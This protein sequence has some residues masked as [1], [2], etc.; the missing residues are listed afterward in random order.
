MF[1]VA[2]LITSM[3][4]ISNTIRITIFSRRREIEIMK[5]VGATNWFIRWPFIVEGML[6]GLIGAVVP[7]LVL[8]YG[9]RSLYIRAK[10]VFSGLSFPLVQAGDLGVKLAVILL[11]IGLFI[12]LW[13]ASCLFAASSVFKGANEFAHQSRRDTSTCI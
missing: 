7:V 5:L 8:V 12:G 2:L 4:L 10:G 11:A 6:I 13:G 9:Y 3:F 1:V